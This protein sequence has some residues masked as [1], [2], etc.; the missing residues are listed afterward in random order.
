[1]NF[2]ELQ[3]RSRARSTSLIVLFVL[4]VAAIIAAVYTAVVA[5]MGSSGAAGP[6]GVRIVWFNPE[7][8]AWVALACL[9]VILSGSFIKWAALRQGGP[10]VAESLG[11]REV[12]PASTDPRERV[13]V[14]VV[15]EMALAAG[16]PVPAI[17]VLDQEAGINA[18]AAGYGVE[19]AVV[20]VTRGCLEQLR[21]DELQGVVAHEF[22]HILNG[23]MR[24][25]IRLIALISG[26]LVLA[27]IGRIMLGSGRRS[28]RSKNSGPVVMMGLALF[29]IGYIGVLVSRII[30]SAVSRQREFLADAAAVQFTRNPRG[31]AGALKKIGGFAAGSTVAS[32]AAAETGHLFFGR[33]V[34]SIFATHPPLAER[35]RRLTGGYSEPA[36]DGISE[37]LSGRGPVSAAVHAGV[38]GMTGSMAGDAFV[39]S[40][41]T[42]PQAAI[43]RSVGM[44]DALPAG[45]RDD[46]HEPYGACCV[47][48]ALLLDRNPREKY[49]QLQAL[50][51]AV[52][53]GMLMR[54][55]R[56]HE[57]LAGLEPDM[58]LGLLDLSIPALRHLS[59]RQYTHFKQHIRILVDADSAISL[60]EFTVQQIL[61]HRLEVVFNRRGHSE[62]YRSIEPLLDDAVI[63]I[64]RLAAEG[65]AEPAEIQQAFAAALRRIPLSAASN[66]QARD[67]SLQQVETALSKFA[68]S[69]PGVK[70]VLLEACA[71]CVLH[72]QQ[73]T[74]AEAGLLRAIAYA[75]DV[76]IPLPVSQTT[77]AGSAQKQQRGLLS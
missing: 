8:F 23:D 7:L 65:H 71:Q 56:L 36:C 31:I 12:C 21:R 68:A 20:A 32:P 24:L 69:R 64:S 40:A 46:V 6:D 54:D 39:H 53:A 14:N 76:P 2:F 26:I 62:V 27:V 1:M 3:D 63:I 30:Q 61:L 16:V 49:K 77:H 15:E 66:L 70:R 17:Y 55:E 33:A 37:P 51:A 18:F 58:V 4:G 29:I 28:T 10:A 75:L 22:S 73:V 47:V 9:T 60:F 67:A 11:G 34:R 74:V 35:I 25:N 19:D 52:P 45:L 38:S 59:P 42:M 41:G 57:P 50:A 44:L 48:Y 43:A 5:I 72:D 13:L